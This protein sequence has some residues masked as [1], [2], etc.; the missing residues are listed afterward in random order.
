[1]R[2][3]KTGGSGL[4]ESKMKFEAPLLPWP[5]EWKTKKPQAIA[6]LGVLLFGA[7]SIVFIPFSI[8]AAANGDT[9][10]MIYGIAGVFMCLTFVAIGMPR[11]WV[12]RKGL[13][14]AMVVGETVKGNRGLRLLY[15]SSWK[16][17]L[18][19]WLIACVAFLGLRGLSFLF[20]MNDDADSAGR[21]SINLGGFAIALVAAVVA[22]FLLLLTFLGRGPRRGWITLDDVGIS[23]VAG[24]TSRAIS[25]ESIGGISAHLIN[26]SHA[27]R[28]TPA[29]GAKF[30]VATGRSLL[31]RWQQGFL[32]QAMDV[33]VWVLGMDPAL[34]LHLTRFYWQHPEARHE[35]GTDATV[36]RIRRGDLLD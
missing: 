30:Q 19:L 34:F 3:L 5:A 13:P 33:P 31:G 28:I 20:S 6:L 15:L 12:R 27:V 1:M 35:L 32:E 7:A 17:V 26:N 29:I 16:I 23:Q 22:I 18:F 8:E 2:T 14:R 24:N 36:D 25:W 4:P 10:R 21:Q 11:V 9:F